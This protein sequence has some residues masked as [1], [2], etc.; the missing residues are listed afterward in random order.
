MIFFYL[1]VVGYFP[2]S[3]NS[4][5][6]ALSDI[7]DPR[8][9]S[10]WVLDHHHQSDI[11]LAYAGLKLV[12]LQLFK[13]DLLTEGQVTA[14]IINKMKSFTE[15]GSSKLGLSSAFMHPS[16]ESDHHQIGLI[17]TLDNEDENLNISSNSITCLSRC[18]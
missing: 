1:K 4:L 11:V 3:G 8:H 2:P 5:C 17:Y 9:H 12:A 6:Y 16:S 15:N 7:Q 18:N 13:K 14:T 10:N